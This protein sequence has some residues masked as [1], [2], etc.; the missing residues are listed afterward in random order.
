MHATLTTMAV[1]VLPR[2]AKVEML[3]N[4]LTAMTNVL[5]TIAMPKDKA[6]VTI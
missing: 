5:H 6:R 4:G 1:G 2:W 3:S